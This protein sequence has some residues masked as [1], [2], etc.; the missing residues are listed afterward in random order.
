[1]N[2]SSA[3]VRRR[4]T[5]SP[6]RRQLS[7]PRVAEMVADELRARIVN[8]DLAD[9][10]LL[11]RQEDLAE[12]FHISMPSLREAMRILET[13]GLL[14]VRRGNV[15]GALVH[16]PSPQAAAFMLGLVLQSHH[17]VLGDLA[18]ALRIVEPACAR[19]CAEQRSRRRIA[20]E[21]QA[22]TAE[23]RAHEEQGTEFTP[24]AREFH[25]ALARLCGNETL[26]QVVGTL[27]TLWS[28]YES[29]WAES[30]TRTG[31][32]PAVELREEVIAAHTAISNAIAI[33]EAETAEKAAR[34]HLEQTQQFVLQTEAKQPVAIA[35]LHGG[36]G[37]LRS[38][39]RT[40][41]A[42]RR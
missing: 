25:D 39:S 18:A 32:Y 24:R 37:S 41:P 12:E 1:M 40:G 42:S 4:R 17:V 14:S 6:R 26:R 10:S 35:R 33:G 29:R 38:W 23:A 34:R 28:D 19:L 8:G 30:T 15:G 7:Q 3:S 21:L 13:E 31:S 22:L 20:N 27:E 5:L 36:F 11:P 16:R 2:E 9:G